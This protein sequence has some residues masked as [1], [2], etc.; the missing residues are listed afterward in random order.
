MTAPPSPLAANTVLA[1]ALLLAAPW[2]RA[3]AQDTLSITPGVSVMHD[4]NLF[5]QS[6]GA[7]SEDVT[8]SSLTL[9]LNKSYSLQRF[10]L[11]TS[12]IDYR[13]K[14]FSYL[15]YDDTPYK[16][17]WRW[18]LTPYLHGNLT[19]DRATTLNSFADYT[20]FTQ[21]NTHTTENS[22]FD[23]VLDVSPSWHLLAGVSESTTT[24]SQITL[25]ESDTRIKRAEAGIR[26]TFSSGSSLSYVNRSG[27]GDYLNRPQPLPAP[28]YL[29]TRF[30]D[31]ENEVRMLWTL[32]GKTS[33]DARLAHLQ[34]NHANFA[35]R[36]YGGNVGTINVNWNI[37]GKALL[38]AVVS[39]ELAAYQTSDANY[40]VTDRIALMPFWQFSA[41]TALRARYDYARRDY[42][43][44]PGTL[45]AS[46]R[47]DTLR[48]ALVALEWQPLRNAIL[49]ASL[50]NERR[51]SN[52]PGLEYKDN[53]INVSAQFTF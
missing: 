20:G 10:E 32:T 16:A 3:D 52:Q 26:H 28:S 48:T 30:D 44:S 22:R 36:D 41:K 14:N 21:R 53:M 29:D 40:S 23:G 8:V 43:G 7:Q 33:V 49:S 17:A 6:S 51:A 12:Y 18:S 50:Q 27:R 24:N 25:G 42:L 5:R 38:T 35:T 13:Y 39:R 31:S 11:E 4:D 34:R 19:T 46:Q 37:S 47:N 1:L 15:S 9:K 45:P 2:A